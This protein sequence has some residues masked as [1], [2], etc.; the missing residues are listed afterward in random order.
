MVELD[1]A[2]VLSI[3]RKLKSQEVVRHGFMSNFLFQ[4]ISNIFGAPGVVKEIVEKLSPAREDPKKRGTESLQHISDISVD[5]NGNAEVSN[6]IVIGKAQGLFGEKHYQEIAAEIE[7]RLSGLSGSGSISAVEQSISKLAD[8][9]KERIRQE[10]VAPVMDAYEVK[11]GT[12][13]RV[14][15]QVDQ[16]I[17]LKFEQLRSDYTQQAN[18]AKAEL[19]RRPHAAET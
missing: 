2:Q 10:V 19:D 1:A 11:S 3:P 14:E 4:N 7:P 12:Q 6:E 5:G 18:I 16:E 9:V 15:R 13:N 8:T 17:D